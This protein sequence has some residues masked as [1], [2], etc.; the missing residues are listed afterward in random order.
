MIDAG[1]IVG[2]KYE[3]VSQI[4][5]GGMG[6]VWRARHQ[7]LGHDI[8]VKFLTHL[9]SNSEQVV[10]RFLDEARTAASVRHRNVVHILDF[11]VSDGGGRPYMVMEFLEGESLA[12]RLER[13]PPL[14]LAETTQTIGLT[15]GGL[16]A[17]H[18]R[19]IVHRDL[20][21]EN[22]FLTYDAD[23]FFPKILDFGVSKDLGRE[24]EGSR[25]VKTRAGVLLGT[26]QYMSPEQARGLRDVDRRTD[27]YSMGVIL[28]EMIS[29]ERPF[30]AENI[31]DILVKVI[32]GEHRLLSEVRPDMPKALT[33]VVEKAMAADR[34]KRFPDAREMRNA[35][36]AAM[37]TS[38]PAAFGITDPSGALNAELASA[39]VQALAR[40][41][42]TP[43][44]SRVD[45]TPR[46]LASSAQHA[47]PLGSSTRVSTTS[48]DE[49]IPFRTDSDAGRAL[50]SGLVKLPPPPPPTGRA[51]DPDRADPTVRMPDSELPT[52]GST[53]RGPKIAMGL[54]FAGLV[55]LASVEA[56]SPG[57]IARA[58]N[59]LGRM[60]SSAFGGA[61]SPAP[62][63]GV[64]EPDAGPTTITVRFRPV[65]DDAVITIGGETYQPDELATYRSDAGLVSIEVPRSDE[66][67]LIRVEAPG[68][69]PYENRRIG[70]TNLSFRLR[71]RPLDA[72][73]DGAVPGD[74]VEPAIDAAMPEPE[75]E[76]APTPRRSNRRRRR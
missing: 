11:G 24:E 55:L 12:D 37:A 47:L 62:D 59:T 75:P 21:P 2:G 61:A 70:S 73:V 72:G 6:V 29:G 51:S 54:F 43:P 74:E 39:V 41:Q 65:P 57:A 42:P 58:T 33:D 18:D 14:S 23:G 66:E 63:A 67:I 16:A 15:L 5:E 50:P 3:L 8:A 17:V 22:I 48:I 68:F 53:G 46:D 40:S 36:F 35:L 64:L 69:E 25:M 26:P 56:S 32:S 31:G 52:E 76:E 9:A 49:T 34:D 60:A 4:G 1:A 19:G 44:E 7:H 38:R 20:K 30:E 45:P 71:L 27:V 28:Y 10:A 13:K